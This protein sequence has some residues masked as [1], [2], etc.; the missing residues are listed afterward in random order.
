MHR[1]SR[2]ILAAVVIFSILGMIASDAAAQSN[3]NQSLVP[4]LGPLPP[5]PPLPESPM[6][7]AE[8][9]GTVLRLNLRD[10]A[11]LAIQYNL[12]LAI[13]DLNEELK[14]QEIVKAHGA[15][16]P[17]LSANVGLFSQKAA[18]TN[19]STIS[20]QGKYNKFDVGYWNFQFKQN[21]KTGGN[22]TAVF[23]SNKS[24][25]NQSFFIFNPQYNAAT[26]VT[27]VQPLLR[28]FRID[29]NR[30]NILLADVNLKI[31]DS[32]SRQ[33]VVDTIAQILGQYW[34]LVGAMRDYE[35]KRE[36][37]RLAQVT[38]RDNQRRME[39]GTGTS[40]AVTEARA[41][42]AQ[43]EVDLTTV[44]E[45]IMIAENI[46][47]AAISNDRRSEIWGKFI[48]PADAPDYQEFTI[49][50]EDATET[51]LKNR[52]E[53]QQIDLNLRGNDI[54]QRMG[55]SYR[56]W[57]VDLTASFGTSAVAGPQ[58]LII[59]PLTGTSQITIAPELVGGMGHAYKLL[60]TGGFTNWMV[61]FNL[62]IPLGNKN[63]DSQLAQV[64]IDSRQQLMRRK[65]TEQQIRVEVRNAYQKMET[66]RKQ[67]DT[68]KVSLE[69]A[70]K[71]LW[72]EERRLQSG[73]SQTFLVLQRQNEYSA[74]QGTELQALIAYKKS[75]IALQRA[76]N[77]LLESN[78]F[79]LA[80][81]RPAPT[82][83]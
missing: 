58:S 44:E 27:F 45:L 9:D 80:Q 52:M 30:G 28:G 59:D 2:L 67:I 26:T 70:K 51:A 25:S 10:I 60:F 1:R 46:G 17:T 65:N 74:A 53:L 69:L 35:I 54:Y 77:T 33:K 19:L 7:K 40:L 64:K 31:S 42:V 36:S 48:V 11:K 61:G 68:A 43:R 37:M 78:G 55:E 76:M 72:G 24:D 13:S 62:Q 3:E 66:S 14:K 32:Q 83:K 81:A 41:T 57:Q 79:E 21:I 49:D 12:D 34:D 23:N 8:K 6:E 38:L 56:K 4:K 75:I 20:L 73:A 15:Y 71:Q 47:R 18:N 5:L 16:D 82:L 22:L 39:I 50:L 29:Q 63:V